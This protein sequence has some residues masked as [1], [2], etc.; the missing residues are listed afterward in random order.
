MTIVMAARGDDRSVGSTV[1]LSGCV[2]G[3]VLESGMFGNWLASAL[4]LVAA[5]GL[6]ATI[7]F[8]DGFA[9]TALQVPPNRNARHAH[10][11][12]WLRQRTGTTN[13]LR[14]HLAELGC[15]A[16]KGPAHIDRSKVVIGDE[17]EAVAAGEAG[18]GMWRGTLIPPLKWRH[19]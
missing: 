7:G 17:P 12:S 9:V 1:A 5:I 3:R 13:A 6:G 4:V 16:P 18:C 10:R 15:I 8:V 2:A 19:R 14:A 11:R